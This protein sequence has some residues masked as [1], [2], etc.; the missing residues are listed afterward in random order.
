MSQKIKHRLSEQR[1]S[2]RQ[3]EQQPVHQSLIFDV[4]IGVIKCL[5][6]TDLQLRCFRNASVLL[7]PFCH[8]V[9]DGGMRAASFAGVPNVTNTVNCFQIKQCFGAVKF[10]PWYHSVIFIVLFIGLREFLC[11]TLAFCVRVFKY[12]RTGGGN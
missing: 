11:A 2:N 7:D 4:L 12:A 3:N 8:G 10:E 9:V 1:R 6:E 5:F